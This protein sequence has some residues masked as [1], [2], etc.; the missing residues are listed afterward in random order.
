MATRS[1]RTTT[2]NVLWTTHDGQHNLPGHRAL[3]KRTKATS[4]YICKC[5]HITCWGLFTNRFYSCSQNC[6]NNQHD[7][8]KELALLSSLHGQAMST[9]RFN[10]DFSISI[11]GHAAHRKSAP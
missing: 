4:K 1:L 2:A 9:P 3:E 10:R 6:I 7:M 5:K 11:C 8:S